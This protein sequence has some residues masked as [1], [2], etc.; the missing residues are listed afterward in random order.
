MQLL[1]FLVE[2]DLL[3]LLRVREALMVFEKQ[4]MVWLP[5]GRGGLEVINGQ[6]HQ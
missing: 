2:T 1:A 3:T 5:E 6:S 4:V